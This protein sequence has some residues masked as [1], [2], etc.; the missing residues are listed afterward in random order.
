MHPL[1]W[2]QQPKEGSLDRIW[3]AGLSSW[4][5]G[6]LGGEGNEVTSYLLFMYSRHQMTYGPV[7]VRSPGPG[8]PALEDL[9]P[10]SFG[11]E[12]LQEKCL[13][14]VCTVRTTLTS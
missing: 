10:V 13:N 2:G 14:D 6:S 12:D 9:L 4:G 8:T 5:K 3:R 1:V 7:P 11:P